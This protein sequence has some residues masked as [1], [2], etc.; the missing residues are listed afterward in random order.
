MRDPNDLIPNDHVSAVNFFDRVFSSPLN[1]KTID[2]IR[3]GLDFFCPPLLKDVVDDY[4]AIFGPI[5]SPDLRYGEVPWSREDRIAGQYHEHLWDV[6]DR[7]LLGDYNYEGVKFLTKITQFFCRTAWET[8]PYEQGRRSLTPGSTIVMAPEV[9]PERRGSVETR[10]TEAMSLTLYAWVVKAPTG[11]IPLEAKL[12]R[13]LTE[14]ERAAEPVNIRDLVGR[15]LNYYR[16]VGWSMGMDSWSNN[17]NLPPKITIEGIRRNPQ[18]V[19]SPR[20]IVPSGFSI[21]GQLVSVEIE[22][23]FYRDMAKLG[24]EMPRLLF[25]PGGSATDRSMGIVDAGVVV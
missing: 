15:L 9:R 20:I 17:A 6:D 24:N 4:A 19:T 5:Y 2:N 3:W 18:G 13:E 11:F 25:L 8:L 1:P 12:C 10:H 16:G 14:E 7:P 23:D 22:D 21:G